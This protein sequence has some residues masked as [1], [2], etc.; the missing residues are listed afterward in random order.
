MRNRK[1]NKGFIVLSVIILLMIT[2][3][4]F[5]PLLTP[6]DPYET[7]TSNVLAAPSGAHLFGTDSNGRDVLSRV[8]IGSRTSIFSAFALIIVSGTVGTIIGLTGGYFKG[9][10]DAILM[11]I[12]DIFLAFPSLILA[13]AV[14]GVLGG[15]LFNAMIAMFLTT[16]TQYARL[17]R[18]STIA[19]K[20]E[21]FVQAAKLSGC[22]DAKILFVHILP[23]IL[24]PLA[25]TA[26]LHI[27]GMMMGLAGLSFL[28]LGVK[29]PA[30]EWGSMIS[31]GRAYLQTAPWVAIMP[32]LVMVSVMMV[33]NMFGDNVR[34]MIDPKSKK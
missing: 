2:A 14:A 19:V 15:G 20:E 6:Y 27:S 32:S 29:V 9:K 31:D 13:I 4:L 23:N 24:G 30:A 21:T 1:I 3:S 33:F 18:S 16:W 28:G 25:V 22:S 17:A 26:T 11:R 7:D 5:A 12:T 34:D 8:I 10:V